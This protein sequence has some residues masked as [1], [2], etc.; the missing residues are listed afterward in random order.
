MFTYEMST[1]KDGWRC[2]SRRIL[3][4]DDDDNNRQLA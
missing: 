3:F 2:S 4:E 1:P